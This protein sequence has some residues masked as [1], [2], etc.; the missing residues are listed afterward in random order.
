STGPRRSPCTA[1]GAPGAGQTRNPSA[2]PPATPCRTPP[3]TRPA[4]PAAAP[5]LTPPP[6]AAPLSGRPP[7]DHLQDRLHPVGHIPVG[8]HLP[9]L[10]DDR[11]L[12][13]LAVHVDSDVNR[14][15]RPLFRARL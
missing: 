14:H 9:R 7:A 12:G 8:E 4:V 2:A 10:V 5:R 13:A 1:A 6:G 3:R 15:C 11:H